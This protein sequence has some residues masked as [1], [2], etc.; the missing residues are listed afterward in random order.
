[1]KIS[2]SALIRTI[3]LVIALINSVLTM[4]DINPLPFSDEE[5]YQGASAVITVAAALIAWWK[6][7]SFTSKAIEADKL[8][9]QLKEDELYG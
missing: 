9:K 5:I 4:C 7:N 3:V 2:K 6:N 1:M 8:L